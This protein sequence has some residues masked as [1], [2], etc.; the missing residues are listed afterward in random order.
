MSRKTVVATLTGLV[1][2]AGMGAPA[3]AGPLGDDE[4]RACLRMDSDTGKRDG[5]CVAVPI[6]RR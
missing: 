2:L 4:T 1:L 6:G 3:L 5:V